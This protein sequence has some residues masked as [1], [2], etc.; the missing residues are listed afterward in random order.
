MSPMNAIRG[1]LNG[2]PLL[3]PSHEMVYGL[4]IMTN[5]NPAVDDTSWPTR[6]E[7][8]L[9]RIEHLVEM[10]ELK[11]WTPFRYRPHGRVNQLGR[12]GRIHHLGHDILR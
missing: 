3:L 4:Y 6:V 1:S 2:S 9:E 8:S 11:D 5:F 7:K 10:G 12:I